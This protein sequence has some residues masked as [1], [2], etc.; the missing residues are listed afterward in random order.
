MAAGDG[1]WVDDGAGRKEGR[2]DVAVIAKFGRSRA[3]DLVGCTIAVGE[4]GEGTDG[5]RKG[6]GGKE[7]RYG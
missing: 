4:G 7:G 5:R 1:W 2:V 6:W 3:N